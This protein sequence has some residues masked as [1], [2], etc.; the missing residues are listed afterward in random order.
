MNIINIIIIIYIY[1]F[2]SSFIHWLYP[3]FLTPGSMP[4]YFR[5][6]LRHPKS[7]GPWGPNIQNQ[8]RLISK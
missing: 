6:V 5:E 3:Q 1:A 8:G 4:T 7:E 2:I